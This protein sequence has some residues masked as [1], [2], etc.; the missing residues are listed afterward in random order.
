MASKATSHRGP[1]S[2]GRPGFLSRWT[3]LMRCCLIINR[4][5][6]G[7]ISLLI[8]SLISLVDQFFVA[9]I[10]PVPPAPQ[11]QERCDI[12]HQEE[13]CMATARALSEWSQEE[14]GFLQKN[15]LSMF[16]GE[17]EEFAPSLNG[18][19]KYS[20]SGSPL[21]GLLLKYL[22]RHHHLS[23]V[24]PHVIAR[25]P[26]HICWIRS[27]TSCWFGSIHRSEQQAPEPKAGRETGGR[28]QQREDEMLVPF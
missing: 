28:A 21:C 10:S 20:Y 24:Y 6:Q 26:A 2:S 11:R 1:H 8:S 19:R 5:M 3:M 9:A 25:Q 23:T 4:C 22:I 12:V 14:H 13:P 15:I 17:G 16:G 18:R 27:L 7:L